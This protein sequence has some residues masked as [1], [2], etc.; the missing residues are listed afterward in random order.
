MLQGAKTERDAIERHRSKLQVSLGLISASATWYPA[1]TARGEAWVMSTSPESV[2]LR[3]VR[4][5]LLYLTAAQNFVVQHH[6]RLELTAGL[7]SGYKCHFTG[8]AYSIGLS[9]DPADVLLE[10]HWHP[11]DLRYTHA[12]VHVRDETLGEVGKLHLPTSRVYFEQVV[13]FLIV[14]LEIEHTRGDWRDVLA[15]IRRDVDAASTWTGDRP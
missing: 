7:I 9:Q 6:H 11:P 2:E 3:T 15:A 13:G 4:G 12:H 10:W 14:G 1:K 5:S 8:Y